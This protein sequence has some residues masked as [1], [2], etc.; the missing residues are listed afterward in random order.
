MKLKVIIVEPRYQINLGYMARISKNFGVRRLYFVRPSAKL[1]GARAIMFAK[2]AKE[3]LLNAKVYPDFDSAIRGCDIVI[4]TTGIWRK[5]KANFKRIYLLDQTI[6]RLRKIGK[7]STVVGLVIGRDSIGLLNSELERCDMI[8]YIGSN[9]EY[10][11]L[12]ISHALAIFLHAF[13]RE[14]FSMQYKEISNRAL[15]E[16]ELSHLFKLFD[17]MMAKKKI[18]DRRAVRSVFKRLVY[19]SQPN[20]KEVHAL[21]TALK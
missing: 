2:H 19:L 4:G 7:D 16:R 20:G 3:L 12:N 21:I 18:R 9:P 1:N 10:P 15:D 8:T 17:R 11:V 14:G 6:S 5:A 13:T